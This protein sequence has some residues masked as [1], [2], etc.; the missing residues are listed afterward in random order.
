M[1]EEW[2]DRDRVNEIKYAVQDL[3]DEFDGMVEKKIALQEVNP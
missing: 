3:L 1:D 2:F